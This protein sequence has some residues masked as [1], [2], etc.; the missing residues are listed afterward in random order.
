MPTSFWSYT[1]DLT[2]NTIGCIKL[3]YKFILVSFLLTYKYHQ[4]PKA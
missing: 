2:A 4:Y 1:N 3:I